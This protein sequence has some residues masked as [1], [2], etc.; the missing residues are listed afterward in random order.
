M[1]K[2][3]TFFALPLPEDWKK[4]IFEIQSDLKEKVISKAGWVKPENLH[5]T[6]RFLGDVAEGEL[7]AI[8]AAADQIKFSAFELESSGADGFPSLLNPR[9]L[10]MGLSRGGKETA[11][12]AD[13]LHAKL[14]SLVPGGRREN[15]NAHVTLARIRKQGGDNWEKIMQPFESIDLPCF[16]ATSFGLYKSELRPSGPVYTELK[17][18]S[19]Y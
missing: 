6:L 7:E 4:S 5:I 10:W 16:E 17:R 15:F 12:L 14:D 13:L 11:D 18:F 2:I 8:C 19:L 1:K 9:V 3:R